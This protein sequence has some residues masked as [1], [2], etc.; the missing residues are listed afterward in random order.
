MTVQATPTGRD[1]FP[2]ST[3]PMSIGLMMPMAENSAFGGSPTYSDIRDMAI[4]AEEAGFDGISF[5]DHF[6]SRPDD[7]QGVRGFW[8]AFTIM[9][10]VAEATTTIRLMP[11]VACALYRNPFLT[12]K[13]AETLD[14]ISQGR[15]ILGLGAGWSK[16]D[17]DMAGLPFDWRVSR[18]EETLE[19]LAGLL[20]GENVNY[21]GRFHSAHDAMNAPRG[22]SASSG[23]VPILLGTKGD[24]MMA[25]TA[26]HADGWNAVYYKDPADLMPLLDKLGEACRRIGRDPATMYKTAGGHIAMEGYLGFRPDPI[27]G[28]AAA[29]ATALTT[30]RDAGIRH[31]VASLDPCTPSSIRAFA[32]VLQ[33]LDRMPATP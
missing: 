10:A 7:P 20:Q 2:N 19:I 9:A 30:F 31:F 6:V 18:F 5:A 15:F 8:E 17:F 3:R 16:P 12:A 23:G 1:L 13:M 28:D 25:L 22:P 14:D 29:V 21:E 4:A 33:R 32:G 11:L 26:Q 24:R 27:V